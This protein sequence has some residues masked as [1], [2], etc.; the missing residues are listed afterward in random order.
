[1]HNRRNLSINI[2]YLTEMKSIFH[3][4]KSTAIKFKGAALWLVFNYLLLWLRWDTKAIEEEEK[5]RHSRKDFIV[6][7]TCLYVQKFMKWT[8]VA[9]LSLMRRFT[10]MMTDFFFLS[11]FLSQL[12]AHSHTLTFDTTYTDHLQYIFR[13]IYLSIFFTKR[14]CSK[15]IKRLYLLQHDKYPHIQPETNWMPYNTTVVT[16]AAI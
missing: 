13:S 1:M 16:K 7:I 4:W 2:R 14:V 12:L 8:H 9:S 5:N 3:M 10:K 15:F 6:E 11:V